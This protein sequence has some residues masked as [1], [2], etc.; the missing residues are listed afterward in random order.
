MTLRAALI[1]KI[2]WAVLGVALIP[3]TGPNLVLAELKSQDTFFGAPGQGPNY[4]YPNPR[5]A[6]P[7]IDLRT[8]VQPT[9]LGLFG[10]DIV[11]APFS[12]TDWP[13]PRGAIGAVSLRTWIDSLKLPLLGQ[14]RFFGDPDQVKTYSVENPRG[15]VPS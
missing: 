2:P 4:D 7:S 5:G 3:A 14:D 13:N 11:Q 9:N 8:H 15:Y 1:T 12:L 6:I 10:L